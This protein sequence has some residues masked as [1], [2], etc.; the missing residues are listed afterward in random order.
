MGWLENDW[1]LVTIRQAGHFVEH[2]AADLVKDD[3]LNW[4]AQIERSK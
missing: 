1:T 4:F 2:D 3:M